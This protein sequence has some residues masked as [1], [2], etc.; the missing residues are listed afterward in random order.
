MREAILVVPLFNE[1]ARLREGEFLSLARDADLALL[2]VDD[3][4]TDKT[5]D[6]VEE[7]IGQSDGRATLFRL[8][9]N[10]GKAEA[11]R[12]GLLR[13]IDEGATIVGYADADLST[14]AVE[15]AR[16]VSEIRRRPVQVLLGSRVRMLGSD[17]ARRP[18]RHYMGRIFATA[19]SHI[20]RLS[21]YDT[22]CGAKLFRVTPVLR[23]ALG[24]PFA[25]RWA[26]DVE[27]LGRLL[28][29]AG[30]PGYAP[31]DFVEV[32]LLRWRDVGGSK[33]S[34]FAAARAGLDLVR[35]AWRLRRG[36]R[37]RP[38]GPAPGAP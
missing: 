11:V 24:Q 16:L 19:A 21:V 26:F 5:A 34:T 14:P 12:H 4:S 7:L 33:L 22:Q 36:A 31:E 23:A 32:P 30:L 29:R 3:G 2:F 13:A 8:A 18:M 35:I 6:R 38:E 28:A 1:F 27:L 17:I 37:C 10:S 15:L 20:L 25:S 9:R